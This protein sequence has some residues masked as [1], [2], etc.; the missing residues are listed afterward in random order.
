[1][2]RA[3]LGAK[4]IVAEA[5]IASLSVSGLS[6]LELF[7]RVGERLRRV[8]PYAAGCWKRASLSPSAT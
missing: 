5:A 6:A 2:R 8:V 7:A 4:G 3:P 1:M